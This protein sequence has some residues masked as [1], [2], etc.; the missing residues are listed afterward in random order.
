M[1]KTTLEIIEFGSDP[2]DTFYCLVDTNI[3]PGGLNVDKL[4]LSDPRN[5]DTALRESGCIMMFTGDEIGELVARGD[6]DEDHL[7]QSLVQLA[8]DEGMLTKN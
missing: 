3:S 7:H 4:K 2:E 6:L 8:M 5:F 1:Q